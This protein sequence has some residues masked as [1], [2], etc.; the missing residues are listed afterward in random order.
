MILYHGTNVDFKVI[1]LA[2]ELEFRGLNKQYYFGTQQA[3]ELLK[4]YE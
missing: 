3:I 2:K 4:R 1:E